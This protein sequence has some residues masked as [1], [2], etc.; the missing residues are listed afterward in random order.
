MMSSLEKQE[1]KNLNKKNSALRQKVDTLEKRES[2]ARKRQ[3]RRLELGQAKLKDLTPALAKLNIPRNEQDTLQQIVATSGESRKVQEYV[4]CLT[5]PKF[6]RSRV[7]DAYARKTA[8][9]GSV[10]TIDV[11]ANF[12]GSSDDG[13]FS[14][15]IQPHLGALTTPAKYKVAMIDSSASWPQYNTLPASFVSASNG[16]DIRLDTLAQRLTQPPAACAFLT[17]TVNGDSLSPFGGVGTV[18]SI[19]GYGLI[20][21]YA[22]G[23]SQFVA[24]PGTYMVTLTVAS[25][26]N[27]A[28]TQLTITVTTNAGSYWQPIKSTYGTLEILGDQEVSTV[29]GL[30][31]CGP[32]SS[33]VIGG[34]LSVSTN[35]ASTVAGQCVASF[36]TTFDDDTNVIGSYDYGDL[37]EYRPVACSAL[38]TSATSSL[39][40]GGMVA[41]A[42][43]PAGA[44]HTQFFGASLN[45]IGDLDSW[46][47]LAQLPGSYNGP[48]K[49][50]AYAWYSPASNDDVAMY[51]PNEALDHKYPSLC[52]SGQLSPG[53]TLPSGVTSIMVGRLEVCSVYEGI[54]TSQLYDSQMM[55]GSQAIMDTVNRHLAVQPHSMQNKKHSDFQ[56]SVIKSAPPKAKNHGMPWLASAIGQAVPWAVTNRNGIADAFGMIGDLASAII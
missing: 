47:S 13:R 50:G 20:I 11:M 35:A 53:G 32:A 10:M 51:T 43:L 31:K 36:S 28:A 41:A 39:I 55:L 6:F 8:L 49:D 27:A 1:L 38:F 48:L 16:R 52:I 33:S 9:F 30:W 19:A 5:A 56:K 40:T 29:V 22:P 26:Q 42:M 34:I 23:P 15:I 18:S 14:A 7:P 25:S 44:A 21:N 37:A 12:H 54:S 4:A 2:R 45:P 17:S 46:E 3:A 24:P